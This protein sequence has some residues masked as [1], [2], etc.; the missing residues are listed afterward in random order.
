LPDQL[1]RSNTPIA[2]VETFRIKVF[3][4]IKQTTCASW[5][6]PITTY[7]ASPPAADTD[8]ELTCPQEMSR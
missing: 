3:E 1:R 6:M 5:G 2:L 8:P 7:L 4:Q